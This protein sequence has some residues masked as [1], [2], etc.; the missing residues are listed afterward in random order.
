VYCANLGL[1][2]VAQSWG[3]DSHRLEVTPPLLP[4]LAAG[5]YYNRVWVITAGCLIWGVMTLGF[6]LAPDIRTAIAFW[7]V[8]GLGLSLVIPNVQVVCAAGVF[9]LVLPP[10][11][12]IMLALLPCLCTQPASAASCPQRAGVC[13]AGGL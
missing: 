5:H 8:N 4:L 12:C 6:S 2:P 13:A 1:T 7:A 9:F 3:A 10:C 11:C